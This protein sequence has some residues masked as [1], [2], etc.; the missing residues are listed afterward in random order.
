MNKL[1]EFRSAAFL[2]RQEGDAKT[3]VILTFSYCIYKLECKER[4]IED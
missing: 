4:G 2:T 3:R 1:R